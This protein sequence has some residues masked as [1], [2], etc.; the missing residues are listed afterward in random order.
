MIRGIFF[1]G[2]GVIAHFDEEVIRTYERQHGL[3][4]GDVVRILYDGP[5]WKDAEL[6][7][8]DENTWLR[9]G[10]R[11]LEELAGP[12]QF[13]D[14]RDAWDRAFLKLDASVLGLAQSLAKSF[15]VGLL[16]NSSSPQPDLERKLGSV[17]ILNVWHTIVNSSDV[18]V[19]KPDKRIYR[20]ASA[21]FGL[22]PPE[23]VHIDDK[24]EN[25][26]GAAAAGFS[27]IHHTGDSAALERQLRL[28]GVAVPAP[29]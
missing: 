2:G 22:T 18:G 19:A 9:V 1:D 8:L 5:E 16:T 11:R 12:L 28:L 6:G 15:K 21:R 25:V 26:E 13:Q 20:I 27:A 29:G 3:E 10:L 14:L 7:A 23:C 4:P 17:G 24:I